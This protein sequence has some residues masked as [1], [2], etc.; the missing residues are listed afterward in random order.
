MI[1]N[2]AEKFKLSIIHRRFLLELGIWMAK[3][4]GI[5]SGDIAQGKLLAI[6]RQFLDETKGKSKVAIFASLYPDK[7]KVE[8]LTV[9]LLSISEIRRQIKPVFD[10]V[11]AGADR[12]ILDKLK[13]A[14]HWRLVIENKF[15]KISRQRAQEK[16]DA[17][18]KETAQKMAEN[19][20][21]VKHFWQINNEIFL[22]LALNFAP[23]IGISPENQEFQDIIARFLLSP[24][25]W[26]TDEL[27]QQ[28]NDPA[29]H[30]EVK[31]LLNSLKYVQAEVKNLT[32]TCKGR[33]TDELI[34]QISN[35][36][37][38][39]KILSRQFFKSTSRDMSRR[40]GYFENEIKV[41]KSYAQS[42]SNE[43]K[44]LKCYTQNLE[45]SIYMFHSELLAEIK[46]LGET[47]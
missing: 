9:L 15:L 29:K 40:I 26:E 36:S 27:S 34:A 24:D 22:K 12:K 10:E 46:K 16:I 7:E 2:D 20:D 30:Y 23:E 5:I 41:L 37:Y 38:W 8:Q 6:L 3:K 11:L 31:T 42:S 32:A 33:F 18:E 28:Y 44:A 13:D 4:Q 14:S 47:K 19:E 43:I 17:L 35:V 39:Q 1:Y 21:L 45:K 25:I